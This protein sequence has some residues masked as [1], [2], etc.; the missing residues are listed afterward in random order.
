MLYHIR[1]QQS[2]VECRVT[3]YANH[4]FQKS[5]LKKISLEN[6]STFLKQAKEQ[7][8]KEKFFLEHNFKWHFLLLQM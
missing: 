3:T 5:S 8:F 6:I 4:R 2:Q 1:K 7:V